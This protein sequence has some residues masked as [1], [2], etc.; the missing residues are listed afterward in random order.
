MSPNGFITGMKMTGNRIGEFEDTSVEF[1]QSEQQK[2]NR[3]KK[4]TC[5]T[6]TRS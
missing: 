5:R 1:T 4:M 2:E 6:I 3:L